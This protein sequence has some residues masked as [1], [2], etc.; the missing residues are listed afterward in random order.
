[1]APTV[2]VTGTT[3]LVLTYS[4]ANDFVTIAALSADTFEIL[5]QGG[6]T[7][8]LNGT[9][10]PTIIT[11]AVNS[12]TVQGSSA[13]GQEVDFDINVQNV[14]LAGA[15]TITGIEFPDVLASTGSLTT[16]SFTESGGPLA[17]TLLDV[18]LTTT[19]AAGI[20]VTGDNSIAVDST[21]TTMA[22]S[23]GPVTL[24]ANAQASSSLTFGAS[25]SIM[26][27]GGVTLTS[28]TTLSLGPVTGASLN[29][30]AG[31]A[32]TQTGIL[33]VTG[34]SSFSAG[35]NPIT[36]GSA[37]DFT[38]AVSLINSGA[39]NVALANSTALVMGTATVGQNLALTA[40][41]SISQTGVLTIPG[42]T[43]LTVTAASSDILLASQANDFT[44][45]VSFAG[46]LSNIRDVGLR[47]TN[48]VA[49]L[50]SLSG[51]TNLRNLTVE[52]D[53]AA[54]ALPTLTLTN[55]GNLSV[56]AGGS[57]TETGPVTVPGTTTLAVTVASSD[58]LLASQANDFTGAVS[59]AGTLSNIRDVG[60][61]N[62][63][64]AA[65]LPSLAG[66]TNLRN[67]TVAFDNAAVALPASTLTS[68][69]S[70][71][72]T[73]GGSITETGALTVP[74]TTTLAVTAASSD[75][76]LASQANDFTGAVS[77][78]GTLSNI[79]DVGLRNTDAA[80][81][82][83]NL[84]GLT[85]LRNLTVEF[86]NAAIALP[87]LT[88]TNSGN[89]SVTA[90][91]AITQTGPLTVPGTSSF[92]TSTNDQLI[93]LANSSNALT[94]AVS[95]VTQ[96]A[97]GNTG[98]V[99]VNNGTT[100][101][102]LGPSTVAGFLNA[103]TSTQIHVAGAVNAGTNPITLTAF[104][105]TQALA[106]VLTGGL[107][108]TISQFGT[109]LNTAT[110]A[111]TSFNAT[112]TFEGG[113]VL[114]DSTPTLTV[115]SINQT[116]S[117]AGSDINVSNAGNL[118]TSG[119]V[120]MTGPVLSNIILTASSGTLTVGAAVNNTTAGGAITL[121]GSVAVAVNAAVGS[122]SDSGAIAIN[123]NTGGSG[124]G[125][126][127][128]NAAGTI[129]TTNATSSAVTI[130]VNAAG[131]GTGG[132]ALDA[133][134]TTGSGGTITITMATGG[135]STG[136]SISQTAGTLNVGTG[137]VALS[138]PTGG[139]SAIGALGTP[140]QTT[141]G[142][143][144]AAA[145]SGGVF[146]TNST[147]ASFTATATAAG[148]I[149]LT[150][151]AGT[152]TIN[153]A[154]NTGSG[155][156]TL[157]GFAAV[158]VNAPLGGAGDSGTIAIKA[159]TGG[160]GAG[161]FSQN[162]AG[163]IQT[164]NATASA[165]TIDVNAAGGGTG[166][167]V[168]VANITTGSGGTITITTAT[169]GNTTGD[170]ITQTAG[171]LNVGTGTVALS[172][173]TTGSSAIGASG[174]PIQTTAGTITAAAGSGGVFITNSTGANF[175]ASATGAGNIML[176][177]TAGT[178]TV[179]G[180][181]STGSGT[182]T[183]SA[184]TGGSGA[185]GFSQTA[186]G[187]I[188]TGKTTAAAVTIDVNAAGGGTGGAALDANITTGSGGTI[189]ITTATGG[190][191]TG[192]SIM[193]TA[194]TLNVGT[195]T[196][197][198]STPTTGSSAIGSAGLPIQ[199]TAGTVTVAAGSGGAFFTNS[200]AVNVTATASGNIIVTTT[201]GIL[202]ITSAINAGSGNIIV[203]GA[204]GVVVEAPLGGAGESGTITIN[205]NTSGSGAGG[206]F[207]NAAG[208]IQTSNATGSAV[209]I[210]VNAAAGGT[211]AAAVG[212]NITTG[213]GG[214]ITITTAT[215]GNT[216][217]GSITET[218]GT[219]NVGTGTV[220]LST[221]TTGSSGIGASG[222]PIQTTAGTITAAAG[223][224]GVFITNSTAAN[225]TATASGAGNITLTTTAGT[226][227]INGA[228]NTVSGNI[229][230][231]G[232]AA[233]A[234]NAPLG[235]AGDSG[236]I[237][238]NAN[239]GGS[240]AGGFSQNA[241]GTIQTSNATGA[242]VTIDVNAAAGGTGS[243]AL[244]A[245]IT[246]GSGGTITITTAAGGNSTGGSITQTAGT[247][248]VGTGTVVLS[249]P[250][251][252]SS[253]IGASGTPIQTTAGTITAAAGSG[254]VFVTNSTGASFTA[255]ATGA[256]N[257]VLM[258]TTGTLTIGGA[259]STGS[260]DVDLV[261]AGAIVLNNSVTTGTGNTVRLRAGT[262][263]M[264]MVGGAG[265]VTAGNL[266]VQ[267]A[268]NVDLCEVA[269]NLGGADPT[270][271][272]IDSATNAFV[273]F[274]NTGT[275]IVGGV[276]GD[277]HLPVGVLELITVDGDVELANKAGLIV[278]NTLI[279]TGAFSSATVRLNAGNSVSQGADGGITSANLLVVAAGSIDLYTTPSQVTGTIALDASS[280]PAG[281]QVAFLDGSG[282]TVGSVSAGICA[283]VGATGVK[284]NAADIYLV[285][286]RFAGGSMEI[287]APVLVT[288]TSAA[289][290][291]IFIKNDAGLGGGGGILVNA[292]VTASATA[293]TVTINDNGLIIINAVITASPT[294]NPATTT[295]AYIVGGA[296]GVATT[297]TIPDYIQGNDTITIDVTGP[298][299]ATNTLNLDGRGGSDT[300]II[301]LGNGVV[302]PININ[303]SGTGSGD[304]DS[305]II[306]APNVNDALV[307]TNSQVTNT[308]ASITQTVT[309]HGLENL[310]INT[311][312]GNDSVNVL[313]TL[314][315]TP[316]TSPTGT[317]VTIN[318]GSGSDTFTISS[319]AQ[320]L[321]Q[322]K[323]PVAIN[324]GTGV[325]VL[326]VNESGS[327]TADNV[328]VTNS[329]ISSTLM[330]GFQPI[331]YEAAAGGSFSTVTLS[332]GSG[333]DTV[334]VQ[335]TSSQAAST[336]VNTNGGNNSITVSSNSLGTGTLGFI[337]GP[338]QINAGPAMSNRLEVS[339]QGSAG[340]SA[341][342]ILTN[343]SIQG[344]GA[345]TISYG[346]AGGFASVVLMLGQGNDSINVRSTLQA[347]A[348]TTVDT[349]AGNDTITVSSA[350]DATG[351]LAAI[352]GAL[353]IN[354]GA[355]ANTL[356][357]SDQ[358]NPGASAYNVLTNASIEGP[359][360][361]PII[362]GTT[363]TFSQLLLSLGQGN[364][365]INV[366]STLAVANTVVQTGAGNDS[367]TVSTS[368][369]GAGL[370][371]FIQGPLTLLSG[372][373]TNTLHVND[374]ANPG[375]SAYNVLTN[376]SIEGPG[377]APIIYG[378]SGTFA[379]VALFMGQGNDSINVR[380]TLAAA[381]VTTINTGAGAASITVST[382]PDGNNGVL[383]FLGGALT[384]N[385]GG[386]ANQLTVSDSGDTGNTPYTVLTN[387]SIERP[388]GVA[389]ILYGGAYANVSLAL[390]KA[391]NILNVRSTLAGAQTTVQDQTG[392][393]TIVVSSSP[394]GTNGIL[395]FIRGALA[396]H[397][398]SGT[399]QL[400]VSEQG[401]GANGLT[402]DDVN[403]DA[404]SIKSLN[405]FF[406][407]I[408][409]SGTFL[410]TTI[411]PNETVNA[412]GVES[413]EGPP[414]GIW[415]RLGMSND[416]L[417]V[418][419]LDANNNLVTQGMSPTSSV[420]IDMGPGD[421]SAVVNVN[422]QS[423]YQGLTIDG[424]FPVPASPLYPNGLA[425][426]FNSI[427][428]FDRSG[429]ATG[430]VFG[431]KLHPIGDITVSYSNGNSSTIN[432][433]DF[434]T[435]GVFAP[436][437]TQIA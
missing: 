150:T 287:L 15:I 258:T 313:S 426:G 315:P 205:A 350:P 50:P 180:P 33:T 54:I 361:V 217:G 312:N 69:G 189:T 396:I 319:L 354:A 12:I 174:T 363:G 155:T 228:T 365:S 42:T 196:V 129:Q 335:G 303:D 68:G 37:N 300:Y 311:A 191:T 130:D 53:N 173:P 154:T 120:T 227:T 267:A 340:A 40:G 124:A 414:A 264:Q 357:V 182:I 178:L 394:D 413:T 78:A 55:G 435:R 386:G 204:A 321:D 185:G 427:Q 176:A 59:F 175:T 347:A 375:A 94:G 331:T 283:T 95:F 152:L 52:F 34:T 382:T 403:F 360:V 127:S 411:P 76:L 117:F 306:N 222:A 255:T 379:N 280:G 253:A 269:N 90:G 31:G 370:L 329:S 263:V 215:G 91:G 231:N 41:G 184:N 104:D 226:L 251:T 242:A 285:N 281:S 410:P 240:G 11:G 291:T 260:G 23:A 351:S 198:L 83:P 284:S 380:S 202:T 433:V 87:T 67:L 221:P 169:G 256:G 345:R 352:K 177:T 307:V 225:F 137:T 423:K 248:N 218:A 21:L 320:T 437:G 64:A 51:L 2:N 301:N 96:T 224:G 206:F 171:T 167:A 1:L 212:A 305:G 200:T 399:N 216:T 111:V 203:N 145:G 133:N 330:G 187:I 165:V 279:N 80:A 436:N 245:N 128:Q 235:G 369:T 391:T 30:T 293:G 100:F 359:G 296:I 98:N 74:G 122:G 421:D 343:A 308:Y 418:G 195:G 358:A 275:F 355:G 298:T 197:A 273:Y 429:G 9:N 207:Q 159:N 371:Q 274:K 134:I 282:F 99:T 289:A 317:P 366:R 61:R 236:T 161:G 148:N 157:N 432:A 295:N 162:V 151:M 341:Y 234:V 252:G 168:L 44:G 116:S 368:P 322:I 97:G 271:A 17:S 48:A 102:V 193:Q 290:G 238:I 147:D 297:L 75:I 113:V 118:T 214:T 412:S 114:L 385:A 62:T 420:L 84:G 398:G 257:I 249:T 20:S 344:P 377:V 38:G 241:A 417:N 5:P 136:D 156:I 419:T 246:T 388:N 43:T 149:T 286:S 29:V 392:N 153:G 72:V 332:T 26:A 270:F 28:S 71:S 172:T 381:A 367:I 334:N 3:D 14:T 135:N 247:L 261:A 233:V 139:S 190:N 310:A 126:F 39:N 372:G 229:L 35:A 119:A 56:T 164:T 277:A 431:S 86:D 188:Q 209:T 404:D 18:P 112:N 141:A 244:D 208:T 201:A 36:L 383:S 407:P 406:A 46:T 66:L 82:L 146:V 405:G 65:S 390:G 49:T 131:G 6:T 16:A 309:Y 338:L 125:G 292:P 374:Q 32:I 186:A 4:A 170:S 140:I 288:P 93:N 109:L 85:N 318:G 89:L 232:F 323:E 73:A 22:G 395:S 356:R 223:S 88:L 378:T 327:A 342:N 79:R 132:A 316:P 425:T 272:A 400:V 430:T 239:T 265:A 13:S 103:T 254:G 179:N 24:S 424:G 160:G 101:L 243:A 402:P 60:L 276:A 192:G 210:D 268:G 294:G 328:V 230:L 389:P 422:N 373:G 259:T 143:I 337:G 339:D 408:T 70:L 434:A 77:F 348:L 211:G 57:I 393:N 237:T 142:I 353:T 416:L 428:V 219:L 304:V 326:S 138:T 213:S 397:A 409:Y 107:L 45:T 364:D 250:T 384:I 19:A 8:Q 314:A 183:L 325:N 194:G 220:A 299:P 105:I 163:T 27:D 181:V 346:A 115:S 302:S 362:Y 92:T 110:N 278:L 199:T 333:D 266:S 106:G 47:N 415:L 63:D 387:A 58:I 25:G 349:G 10:T 81:T 7:L 108:T 123:A 166:G 401:I 121:N 158:A 324:A 336:I 144:T 376:A 262:S